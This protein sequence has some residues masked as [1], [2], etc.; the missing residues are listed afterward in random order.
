MSSAA[1][2]ELSLGLREVRALRA[3]SP[4]RVSTAIP[5][6]AVLDAEIAHRRASVVLLS[7]HYERYIYSINEQAVDLVNR[8]APNSEQI[9]VTIRLLQAKGAIEV[10]S[11]IEWNQR[12][13]HL[14][15]FSQNNSAHWDPFQSVSNL[16]APP[17]LEWMKAPTLPNVL[18]SFRQ[19]EIDDIL[20]AITRGPSG[21]SRL[22]RYLQGLV[23]A[24]NGIAHGDQTVQPERQ[25]LTNYIVS[26]SDF[27]VRT[28][29]FF[30]GHLRRKF[31]CGLPW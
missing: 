20:G 27:C 23:D 25:D 24:R 1:L 13:K 5:N 14:E 12:A 17:I 2:D 8:L 10:L 15:S 19:W 29:R 16:S 22:A 21:R 3:Y 11:K 31:N 18:R 9:P 30:A 7:S 28:D 26:V 4:R 6:H